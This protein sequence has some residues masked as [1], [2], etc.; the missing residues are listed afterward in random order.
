MRLPSHK[1]FRLGD[2]VAKKMD[3]VEL[4]AKLPKNPLKTKKTRRSGLHNKLRT[5]KT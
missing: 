1:G 3:K 2:R 5:L 4:R